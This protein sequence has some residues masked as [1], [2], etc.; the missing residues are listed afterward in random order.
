MGQGSTS[1]QG[2]EGSKA[3]WRQDSPGRIKRETGPVTSTGS[4]VSPKMSAKTVYHLV[5]HSQDLGVASR[6]REEPLQ[7]LEQGS[8]MISVLE[9]PFF[10][11]F[12]LTH[13]ISRT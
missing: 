12:A 13:V 11:N 6:C 5:G 8:G 10:K 7:D 9:V 2:S 3:V 4:D 1:E